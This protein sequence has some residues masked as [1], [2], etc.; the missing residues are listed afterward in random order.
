[1]SPRTVRRIVQLFNARGVDGLIEK[2]YR[3]RPKKLDQ[4]ARDELMDKF[5]N[6]KQNAPVWSAKKFH[7][8]LREELKLELSYNTVLRMLKEEGLSL[9]VPR[10]WPAD[11]D[12]EKR[13]IFKEEL[14]LLLE[15]KE[16]DVWFGDEVGFEGNTKPRRGWHKKGSRP[17]V[18]KQS[19]RIRRI[20]S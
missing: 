17:R 20:S 9:Q 10:S 8:Y 5:I 11:Q 18:S 15:N 13:R 1:M 12:Q 3:G 2:R 19:L 16:V 6:T 7:G 4:K 14:A